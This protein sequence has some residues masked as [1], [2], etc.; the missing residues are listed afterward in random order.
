[1]IRIIENNIEIVLNK[2]TNKIKITLKPIFTS[3]ALQLKVVPFLIDLLTS[4]TINLKE[5]A[6][7]LKNHSQK[8]SKWIKTLERVFL[9][10]HEV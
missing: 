3:L 7:V 4:L 9:V 2:K 10:N 1:L 5:G 8:Q 6:I